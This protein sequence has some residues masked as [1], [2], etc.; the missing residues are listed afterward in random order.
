MTTADVVNTSYR[1]SVLEKFAITPQKFSQLNRRGGIF[2]SINTYGH[3]GPWKDRAGFDHNAQIATGFSTKEVNNKVPVFSPVSYLN[4]Y[5]TGYLAA[6]SAITALIYR[7]KY[8]G[9]YQLKVSLAKSAMWVQE[10]GYIN[11]QK[12]IN[13]PADD[14]IYPLKYSNFQGAYGTVTHVANPVE[15]SNWPKIKLRPLEPYGA[16]KAEWQGIKT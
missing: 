13:C 4:D 12:Y 8:S 7:A 15:L 14:S 16:S 11:H 1:P 6:T 9:S 10:L 5:L 2:I 3:N